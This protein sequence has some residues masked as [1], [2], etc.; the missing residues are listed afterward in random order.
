MIN[1]NYLRKSVGLGSVCM[2]LICCIPGSYAASPKSDTA[3][4]S[5]EGGSTITVT[6]A[7]S[8]GSGVFVGLSVD[9]KHVKTL[10]QGS[11]YNGTLSPGKHVISVNPDPN[12]SGQRPN[13]V[14]VTAE[15]GHS[16][17][18]SATRSK[19][20]DIVLTKTS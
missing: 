15:K 13:A 3:A 5:G 8:V 2:G 18:F 7:P 16:Y 4:Q 9:G 12:T 17:S 19:S 6:R 14:E 10:M 20:G 11:R 1:I